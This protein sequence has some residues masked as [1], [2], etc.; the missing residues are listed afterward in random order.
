MIQTGA[1]CG[2]TE[3]YACLL[4]R[5]SCIQCV[6]RMCYRIEW[7]FFSETIYLGFG[8]NMKNKETEKI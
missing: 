3:G 8:F 4:E 6:I 2:N 5:P 7:N 1:R